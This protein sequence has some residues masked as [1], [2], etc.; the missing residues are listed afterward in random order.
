MT[1]HFADGRA[2]DFTDQASFKSNDGD[3]ASVNDSR[4]AGRANRRDGDFR[5]GGGKVA[6]APSV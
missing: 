5:A 4:V 3:V 2:E 6:S 1:A